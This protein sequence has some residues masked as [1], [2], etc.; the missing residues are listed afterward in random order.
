MVVVYERCCGLDIHKKTVAAC[1]IA[2]GP[3]GRVRKE[4]RTFGTMTA[5]LLELAAWLQQAGVTHVGM[6][7]TGVYWK[8]VWNIL[9]EAGG[10]EPLL[11]N[12][13]HIKAVP[14]RKTDVKDAEWLA[15]LLRH[16]L[17]KASFIPPLPQ[18]DLR[19]LTR[20]RTNLVQDRARVVN[21][22]QKVLEWANIK[23][24]S[25]VSDIMGVSARTMLA[26]IVG[27]EA[28]Q[29]VL[30]ALGEGRLRAKPAELA[31]AD[32]ARARP[33]PLHAGQAFGAH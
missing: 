12:A 32:G 11:V 6:E 1:L 27:G 20:Q 16:G 8:P 18:R 29:G 2:P 26:A 28:D 30:A 4:V 7:A 15:D 17:L 33:S 22:L 31:R 9:E 25:V 24:S 23:L 10:F 13:H 21:Q 14:G 3:E 19:D 5:E